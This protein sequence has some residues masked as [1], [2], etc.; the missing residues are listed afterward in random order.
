VRT[1]SWEKRAR[2]VG[3]KSVQNKKAKN[4]KAKKT[5][6]HPFEVSPCRYE[7]QSINQS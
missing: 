3:K 6:G 4:K 7:K 5:K 1:N 2:K